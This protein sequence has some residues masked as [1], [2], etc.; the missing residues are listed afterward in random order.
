MPSSRRFPFSS[1]HGMIDGIHGYSPDLGTLPKPTVSSRFADTDIFMFDIAQ[2][3]NRSLTGKEDL[4]DFP[5]RKAYLRI[6][7]LLGHQ[8]TVRTGTADNLPS[9]TD[10][11]FY[12][13]NK[14]AQRDILEGNGVTRFDIGLLTADDHIAQN[15]FIRGEDIPFLAIN[16]VQQGNPR[17]TV[18]IVLNRRHSRRDIYLIPSK[19]DKAV[20]SFMTAADMSARHPAID[21]TPAA[22]LQRTEK[23]FLGLRR[24]YFLK[25]RTRLKSSSR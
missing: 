23:A 15:Y 1:A 20:S 7:T 24:S 2:L 5:G 16:V 4:S 25:I 14:R 13:M 19:I 8:L 9:P 3:T 17:G 10:L 11:K 12:V 18:G 6:S 22:F 21:I